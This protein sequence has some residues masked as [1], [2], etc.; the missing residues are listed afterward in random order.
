[1][2]VQ[3]FVNTVAIGSAFLRDAIGIASM[4]IAS[5]NANGNGSGKACFSAFFHQVAT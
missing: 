2:S 1:M 5:K 4:K 3:G